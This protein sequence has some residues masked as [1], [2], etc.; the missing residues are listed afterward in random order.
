MLNRSRFFSVL[1]AVMVLAGGGC[2]GPAALSRFESKRVCMGVQTRVVLYASDKDA[3]DRA[4]NAAF[5][6]IARLD[7]LMSDYRP[8]S[9][10]MRLC[11]RA[12]EGPVV[13]GPELFEVLSAS[14]RIS[15]ES[16]GAF[17]VT[18]GPA[19]LLWRQVRRTGQAASAE[20]LAAARDLVGWRNVEL[21]PA[22]RTVRLTKPGM[23]LDLGGIAKGYA[24]QRAV[25][26]L[27]ALGVR[28]CLV[29]LAGDIAVGDAP[30]G[31]AGWEIGVTGGQA[32]EGASGRS[33]AAGDA[34][35][36]VRLL[37]RNAAV[38]TSGDTEQFVEIQ[39]QRYSHFVD[40]RTGLGTAGGVSVTVVAERGE[41][42]DALP[43][44]ACVLGAAQTEMFLNAQSGVWAGAAAIIEERTDHGVVRRVVD[45]ARK[46]KWADGVAP[47]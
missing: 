6:R 46:L 16:D 3:A 43:T 22:A 8:A 1:A 33:A 14:E 7:D 19:V 30:P 40:P 13:V 28:C 42:A 37:L 2:A 29:A 34:V 17:D 39:G 15:R 32:A 5:D 12:G 25:D 45:P 11:A 44:A 36:P 27:R 47:R 24:A 18:V 31:R 20:E 23:K 26:E 41:L 4:A 21:D 38:S 9:E 35:A 10:L